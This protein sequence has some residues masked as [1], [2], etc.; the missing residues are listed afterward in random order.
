MSFHCFLSVAGLDIYHAHILNIQHHAANSP[1]LLPHIVES[2]D[3]ENCLTYQRKSCWVIKS[4][5]LMT[6]LTE[7]ALIL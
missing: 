1:F 2:R 5:I 6:S 3:R 4:F 7:K